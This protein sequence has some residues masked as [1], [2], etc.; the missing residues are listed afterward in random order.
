V[1]PSDGNDE[2][3][4][5]TFTKPYETLWGAMARA[6]PRGDRI[7]LRPGEYAEEQLLAASASNKD[8]QIVHDQPQSDGAK[9]S[10]PKFVR[11]TDVERSWRDEAGW[12]PK[13]VVDQA[14]P[15]EHSGEFMS[16]IDFQMRA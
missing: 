9:L 14:M 5:G 10:L 2:K 3:G 8:V 16:E 11:Q 1:D 15:R 7:V 13:V 4:D 12:G 6:E